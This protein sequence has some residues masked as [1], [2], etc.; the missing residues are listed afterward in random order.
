[1]RIKP[2]DLYIGSVFYEC[3]YGMNLRMVTETRPIFENGQWK[4]TARDP[5]DELTY[6]LVTEGYEHYGPKL[7]SEPIYKN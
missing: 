6:Y 4:W 2:E 5:D 3:E 7:Y 1:M